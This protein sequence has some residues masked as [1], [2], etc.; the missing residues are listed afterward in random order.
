VLPDCFVPSRLKLSQVEKMIEVV[1]SIIRK[2]KKKVS[3]M[4]IK[5]AS[6]MYMYYYY[7]FIYFSLLYIFF[8]KTQ[9]KYGGEK[10]WWGTSF[11][12]CS[13]SLIL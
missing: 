7:T 5:C 3:H 4:L 2:K 12:F 13:S 10:G 11:C 9:T 6:T 1:V 8:D